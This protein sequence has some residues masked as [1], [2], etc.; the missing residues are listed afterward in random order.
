M[1]RWHLGAAVG[2]LAVALVLSGCSRTVTGHAGAPSVDLSVRLQRAMNTIRS[3]HTQ[4]HLSSGGIEVR[5]TGSERLDNGKAAAFDLTEHIS[6]TGVLRI[7]EIGNALYVKLPAG[8]DPTNK[9]WVRIDPNT[10]DP[11]L[12]A[13][14]RAL[15]AVQDSAALHQY[16]VL[17]QAAAGIS[18]LGKDTVDG[19]ATEHYSFDVLVDRLPSDIPGASALRAAGVH[20]I[21]VQMWLDGKGRMVRTLESTDVGGL[22]SSTTITLSR[23]DEPVTITAPPPGQVATH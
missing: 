4:L 15:S 9:P 12:A 16:T 19:V 3:V 14:A 7:V 6:G 20:R 18:D 10:T 5:A 2:T 22:Q 11:N 23:F 13:L 21:P 17:A 8:L 1:N